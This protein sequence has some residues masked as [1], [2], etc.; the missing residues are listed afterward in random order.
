M[1]RFTHSANEEV[2]DTNG[3]GLERRRSQQPERT[4]ERPSFPPGPSNI[5][6]WNEYL[7]HWPHLE[8]SVRGGVDGLANRVDRLRLCGNGVVPLAAAYAFH[9]LAFAAGIKI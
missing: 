3:T 7:R 9:T 8:P 1:L 5:A 6:G 2:V 4:D